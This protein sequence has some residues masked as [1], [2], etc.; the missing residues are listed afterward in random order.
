MNGLGRQSDEWTILQNN[1]L[2]YYL[3]FEVL[4]MKYSVNN[5]IKENISYWF[6]IAGLWYH[7]AKM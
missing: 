3:F 7:F 5:I 2:L 4:D 6:N 1:D